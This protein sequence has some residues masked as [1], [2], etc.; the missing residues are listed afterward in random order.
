MKLTPLNS[1]RPGTPEYERPKQDLSSLE[2]LGY[3]LIP[4][5]SLQIFNA[6]PNA[7]HPD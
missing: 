6:N 5:E 2:K 3:V 7:R 1:M 4:V